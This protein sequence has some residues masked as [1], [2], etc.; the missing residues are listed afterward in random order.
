MRAGAA[1]LVALGLPLAVDAAAPPP[2]PPFAAPYT[3]MVPLVLRAARECVLCP[4]IC[5]VAASGLVQ[6]VFALFGRRDAP[7][8]CAPWCRARCLPG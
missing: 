2:E 5:L 4:S 8:R 3:G 7:W 1:E 6:T